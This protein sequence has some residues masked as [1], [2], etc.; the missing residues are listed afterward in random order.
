MDQASMALDSDTVYALISQVKTVYRQLGDAALK[1]KGITEAS[2]GFK[3]GQ[4]VGQTNG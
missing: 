3:E 4:I 2:L 1:L